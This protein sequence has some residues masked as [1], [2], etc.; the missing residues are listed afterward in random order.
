MNDDR[1]RL[2]Q[3]L[4]SGHPCVSILTYEEAQALSLVHAAAG[5]LN[6]AVM[7]WSV[8]SGIRDASTAGGAI[9]SDTEH[10]AAALFFLSTM[11]R[12]NAIVVMLDLIPHLKE[13]R[14]MRALREALAAF[15]KTGSQLVLID[16][17]TDLPPA[18]RAMTTPFDLS[19]P[20]EQELT[21]I[22]RQT[23]AACS[24]PA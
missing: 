12:S 5:E 23:V 16:S 18:L 17:A 11:S 22:I 15:E 8:I 9:V 13:E 21:D 7:Q 2:V 3:L 14:A 1:K 19:L 24:K 4:Q 20:D 10:P 6:R